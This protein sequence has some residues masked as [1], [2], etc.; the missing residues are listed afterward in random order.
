[1]A[2]NQMTGER[3]GRFLTRCGWLVLL[4]LTS[5]A[6]QMPLAA[7]SA[8]TVLVLKSSFVSTYQSLLLT[9]AEVGAADSTSEVTIEFRDASDKQRAFTSGVLVRAQPLRLRVRADAGAREQF[10]AVVMIRPLT[11]AAGSEPTAG[12]EDIDTN[13]LRVDTKPPCAPPSVGGV[14]AQGNCGGW[15]VNR[16]TVEQARGLD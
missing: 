16:L 1:M 14:G 11:N 10:Y 7:Q 5:A 4:V 6:T 3:R 2:H 13:S 8:E 12:L 15:R 9:I